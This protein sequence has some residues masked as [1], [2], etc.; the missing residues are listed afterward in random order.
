MAEKL[1][2]LG[3]PEESDPRSGNGDHSRFN[4]LVEERDPHANRGTAWQRRPGVHEKRH[5]IVETRLPRCGESRGRF[6][7]HL[8]IT[9]DELMLCNVHALLLGVFTICFGCG[10]FWTTQHPNY[11][12]DLTREV[13]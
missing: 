9:H 7:R 8:A 11:S 12:A 10:S 3:S 5:L 2:I 1:R 4:V 13:T 6:V